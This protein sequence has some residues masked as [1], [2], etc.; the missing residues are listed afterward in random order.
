MVK[1]LVTNGKLTWFTVVT[2][3]DVTNGTA[4]TW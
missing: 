2:V 1:N 3:D 4:E